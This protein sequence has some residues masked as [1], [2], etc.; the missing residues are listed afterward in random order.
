[1]KRM[2]RLLALLAA[3]VMTVSMLPATVNAEENVTDSVYEETNSYALN[4]GAKKYGPYNFE[5]P[6]PY[7]PELTYKHVNDTYTERTGV[8]CLYNTLNSEEYINVYCVDEYTR[9]INNR[10]YQRV[11]LED[12]DFYSDETA[13]QLRSIVLKGFPHTSVEKLAEAANVED[14]TLGE[15]VHATQLAIWQT[16]YGDEL[17]INSYVKKIE[18][19]WNDKQ[20]RYHDLCMEEINSGYAVEDNIET[21]SEHVEKVYNYLLSLEPTEPQEVAVSNASFIEWSSS[22]LLTENEDGTYDVTVSATVNVVEKS[23]DALTMSAVLDDYFTTVDLSNGEQE[24]SLTIKNVPSD[25]VQGKVTLAIDGIQTV[26]DVYMF[27][28]D[29][30]RETAQRLIG[31]SDIQ[32]PVHAEVVVEPERILNFYKTTKIAIG[33]DGNGETVYSRLPLSGITFD[34]Y[35]VADLDDYVSGAITLPETIDIGSLGDPT[36]HYPEY[37]VTTDESGKASISLSKN[38][39]PDGVY[40]VKEREHVAIEKPVDPFYIMLPATN[41][42]GDGWVYEITVEPKN[43]VESAPEIKKDVNEIENNSDTVNAGEEF[44][45]I[46]RGDVPSDIKDAKSYVITDTLDY[47]LTYAENLVVKVEPETAEA[48]NST[49]TENVLIE[50]TDYALTVTD[51]DISDDTAAT[52]EIVVSLTASGMRKVAK[53]V[54]DNSEDY[55]VRVYFNT[56]VDEDAS[57]GTNIPNQATLNYTNSVN[58]DFEVDSDIPEVYTC[59]INIYKYDVKNTEKALQGAEFM[60]ARKATAAE[61]ADQNVKTSALVTGSGTIEEVVYVKF[62]NNAELSGDR[63]NTVVTGED[64]KAVIYGLEEVF[65]TV[66]VDGVETTQTASYY[67]VETKAPSGYN[68]LSYPVTVKLDRDSHLEANRV[69]VANSNAFTLPTTGGVGTTIFTVSGM[70][71]VAVAVFLM[72][73]NRRKEDE[74]A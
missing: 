48:D 50:G 12:S 32:L 71:I 72:I 64:G 49:E 74:L 45:W 3:G 29:G 47:R 25:S 4:Y 11:N 26:S 24:V 13:A 70:S 69:E 67:L 9:L 7:Y 8:N 16:A 63:V 46:V 23:G 52:K 43:T 30:E 56:I 21:I 15:A 62:Y 33:V 53:I 35:F 31:Y 19:W 18:A 2:K 34:I 55:E 60:V 44:T 51:K 37:T 27:E 68:L 66:T 41:D 59:G 10:F 42:D 36:Y 40:V 65:E 17:I 38:G 1:M 54:G 5:Y 22:P 20:C 28:V 14:L 6:S 58:F 73:R 39:L 61:I 57:M